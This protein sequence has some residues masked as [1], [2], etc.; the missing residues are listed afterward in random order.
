MTN[1]TAA[2]TSHNKQ[3]QHP[4]YIAN[5]T[6][7]PASAADAEKEAKDRT[8]GDNTHQDMTNI[9]AAHTKPSE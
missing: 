1:I 2:H 5:N 7:K 8:D 3:T 9:T 6:S 4:T